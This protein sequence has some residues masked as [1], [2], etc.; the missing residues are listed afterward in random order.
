MEYFWNK[1]KKYLHKYTNI[2]LNGPYFCI[3]KKDKKK[4]RTKT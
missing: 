1:S 2:F 4:K 3:L